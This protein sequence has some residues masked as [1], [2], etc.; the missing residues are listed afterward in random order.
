MGLLVTIFLVLA[1]M[2]N[3]INSNSP[4]SE[5]QYLCTLRTHTISEQTANLEQ[6]ANLSL[7]GDEPF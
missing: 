2:F 5:G 3:S 4:T 6:K 7:E 1:N